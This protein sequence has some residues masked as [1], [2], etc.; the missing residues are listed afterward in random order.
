MTKALFDAMLVEAE[1]I[2]VRKFDIASKFK[3]MNVVLVSGGAAWSGK[4]L[5]V[6]VLTMFS[7]YSFNLA[8]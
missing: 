4:F 2:I 6:C 1:R 8:Y 5:S 7:Q 3:W